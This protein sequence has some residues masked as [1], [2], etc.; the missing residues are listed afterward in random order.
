MVV[1]SSSP[2]HHYTRSKGHCARLCKQA[3]VRLS[4]CEAGPAAVQTPGKDDL[5]GEDLIRRK[6]DTAETLTARLD[7]FHKQ[8][9]PILQH[10]RDR[11]VDLK[12]DK[13]PEAVAGDV[14]KAM[15]FA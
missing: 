1:P 11:V 12:A 2:H 5:T 8:T 4:A 3:A 15:D 6:D 14:A 9:S 10:Y 13:A 7:A